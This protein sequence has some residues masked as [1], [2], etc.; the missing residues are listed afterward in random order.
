LSSAISGFLLIVIP[1]A[2][3]ATVMFSRGGG[4][5]VGVIV[6]MVG[7]RFRRLALD[8]GKKLSW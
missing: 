2:T 6:L 4:I 3:G 7:Y 8:C 5:L 1:F